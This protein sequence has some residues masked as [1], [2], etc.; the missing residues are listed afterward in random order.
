VDL[1][2]AKA[3]FSIAYR[4]SCPSIVPSAQLKL[5][6]ARHPLLMRWAADHYH[7][8]ANELTDEVVP[9]SPRV[10]DDFDLLLITGPNTGGK[11]V[12]LK[13]LGLCVLMAQA[14]MHVPAGGDSQI[15]VYRQVFADIGDEQSIQESLSTFSAHMRQ[16]VRIMERTGDATLVLLDELGSGTDPAEGA[17][18]AAA[19]LDGLLS[20]A[21]HVVATTHLGELKG[22]A[23]ARSRAE[24][25][26]LQFDTAT[27]QP[28]YRLLMGT[29]G[30][31]NALAIAQR[32]GM[33]K[34]V[35][36]QAKDL[37]GQD[38]DQTSRLINEVQKIRQV[39][40]QRRQEADLALQQAR[41]MKD[42]IGQQVRDLQEQQQR[43]RRQADDAI[44]QS[45]R[46]VRDLVDQFL[47][48]MQNAP[49]PW[50]EQAQ[51]LAEQVNQQA[52]STPLAVR[53]AEFIKALR[54]GDSVYVIPFKRQAIVDR[55][56]HNRRTL[57]VLADGRQL[58]VGFDQVCRPDLGADR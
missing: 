31:S 2:C 26:S 44:D 41:Q 53:H 47:K 8:P 3:R 51:S 54:R 23:F 55:V 38:A 10:G 21:G 56:R 45:L 7:R 34:K 46:P 13:T 28:T 52:A 19:I 50:F 58:E 48:K 9:M 57:V 30:S 39:A 5:Q 25:A 4:L 40:E 22:F 33:P 1:I 42:Q 18:L 15:G 17:A 20:K 36:A 49:K 6:D 24:N 12:L 29:P 14:G 16:I 32:L 35:T 37:L 27:L 43:L 11:T